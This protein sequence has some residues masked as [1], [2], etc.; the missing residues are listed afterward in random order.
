MLTHAPYNSTWIY[1]TSTCWKWCTTIMI[2]DDDK[3]FS[4]E[5]FPSILP[6]LHWYYVCHT[7]KFLSV[8]IGCRIKKFFRKFLFCSQSMRLKHLSYHNCNISFTQ[9]AWQFNQSG[10]LTF[11]GTLGNIGKRSRNS[12]AG[13]LCRKIVSIHIVLWIFV[14]L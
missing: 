14:S 10:D 6:V 2:N 12:E 11:L 3:R 1:Q 4:S 9:R 8:L 13:R 7:T 5:D